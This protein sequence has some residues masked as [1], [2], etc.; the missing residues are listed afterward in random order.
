[1]LE[2]ILLSEG[3]TAGQAGVSA[4]VTRWSFHQC[5]LACAFELVVASYR[6]GSLSFP[7]VLE[8]LQ[9]QPFD[10]VKMVSLFVKAEPSLPRELKRHLFT[11]E[12]KVCMGCVGMGVRDWRRWEPVVFDESLQ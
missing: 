8:R 6:M 9:L 4:L 5:V 1:M 11:I 3:R 7:A 2:S 10:M 12:E